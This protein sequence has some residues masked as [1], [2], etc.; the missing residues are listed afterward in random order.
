MQVGFENAKQNFGQLARIVRSKKWTLSEICSWF[1]SS[2]EAM[3]YL[4]I[5]LPSSI[6]VL[7]PSNKVG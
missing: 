5:A 2:E 7:Q 1:T 3:T 4:P 6:T